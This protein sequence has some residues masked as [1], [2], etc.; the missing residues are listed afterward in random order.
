MCIVEKLETAE[1]Y[2]ENIINVGKEAVQNLT[3]IQEE[4]SH[5]FDDVDSIQS[6]AAAILCANKVSSVK[7]MKI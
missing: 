2:V 1:T 4:A 5:C 3:V 7:R 6:A